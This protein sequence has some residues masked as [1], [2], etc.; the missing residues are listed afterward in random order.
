M[1]PIISIEEIQGILIF[2]FFGIKPKSKTVRTVKT[3]IECPDG[4]LLCPQTAFPTIKK[5]SLLNT[6][7][8]LGTANIFFNEHESMSD[9]KSPEN[10]AS[11][12]LGA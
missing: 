7:A 12:T 2:N 10:K 5:L 6:T 1:N 8:G 9:N 11:Q 4:K 3:V